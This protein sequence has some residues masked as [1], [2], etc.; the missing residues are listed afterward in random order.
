MP[1]D[2]KL[3]ARQTIQERVAEVRRVVEAMAKKLASGQL[4]AIVGPQGAIAFSGL[5]ET[6]RDGVT[7]ACAYRRIMSGTNA[8]AKAAIAKAEALAGRAVD[9][10]VIAH[11]HHSHDG[12]HTWHHGH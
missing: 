9:R 4:R 1:C 7:D 2:T 6:E 8:L 5:T 10:K 3:K 12:G 11:G